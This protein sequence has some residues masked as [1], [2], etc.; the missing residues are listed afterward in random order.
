MVACCKN[1]QCNCEAKK[2]AVIG[3]S[4]RHKNYYDY[5]LENC[6]TVNITRDDYKKLDDFNIK[7]CEERMRL[8][9]KVKN[10]ATAVY[11]EDI[12]S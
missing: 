3:I 8:I 6:P 10:D 11:V 2:L 12:D 4:E 9:K 1:S 5:V 7:M